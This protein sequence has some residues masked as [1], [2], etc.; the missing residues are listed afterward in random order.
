MHVCMRVCFVQNHHFHFQGLEHL[1][2]NGLCHLDIKPDNIFLSQSGT[3]WK[4][5]DFGLVASMDT[6]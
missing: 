4:L 1:H 5:G 6:G 3:T 2:D